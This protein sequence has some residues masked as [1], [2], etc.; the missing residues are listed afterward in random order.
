MVDMVFLVESPLTH[1][2]VC[3]HNHIILYIFLD[4]ITELA[5]KEA[6][7]VG[8]TQVDAEV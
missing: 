3:Y 7:D 4:C 6:P 5:G 2:G 1:K 8:E